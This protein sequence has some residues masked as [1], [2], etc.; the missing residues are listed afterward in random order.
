MD[1]WFEGHGR[2][3]RADVQLLL[4]GHGV[5]EAVVELV[6]LGCLVSFGTTSD[7]GAMALTV[8]LDGRKR[9]EYF[10]DVEELQGWLAEA[11]PAVRATVASLAASSE[12][13]S[14]RRRPEK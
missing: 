6:D 8:M 9:R 4:D 11:L 5:L 10:R 2:G 12:P 14:R 3:S 1:D 13:R 7:G